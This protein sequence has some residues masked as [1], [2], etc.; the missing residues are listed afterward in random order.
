[1]EYYV[2][3][4]ERV[5]VWMCAEVAPPHLLLLLLVGIVL[6]LHCCFY[7][8]KSGTLALSLFILKDVER[9]IQLDKRRNTRMGESRGEFAKGN[10]RNVLC[11]KKESDDG[12]CQQ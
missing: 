6:S 4:E 2:F 11:D 9:V 12:H 8:H 3:A 10:P 5:G 7:L 1:M